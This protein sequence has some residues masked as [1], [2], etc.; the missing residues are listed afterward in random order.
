MSAVLEAATDTKFSV[1]LSDMFHALDLRST[2]VDENEP[3]I[4]NRA[5]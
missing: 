3:I 2:Y 4:R 5:R 1:L